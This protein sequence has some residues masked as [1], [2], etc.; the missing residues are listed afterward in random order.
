M[1]LTKEQSAAALEIFT[2][3]FV[4]NYPGPH[5]IIGD[6]KWHAP[7]IFR[8]ALYAIELERERGTQQVVDE[9]RRAYGP[10]ETPVDNQSA[11]P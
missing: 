1:K 3:Y 4:R 10:R 5:T 7:K 2:E 9:L 6:P 11:D 8:A